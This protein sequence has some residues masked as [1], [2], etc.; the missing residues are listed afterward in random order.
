MLWNFLA[1]ALGGA[2]GSCI[3][4]GVSLCYNGTHSVFALPTL[5]VNVIGSLAIGLLY[6]YCSNYS[7]PTPMKMFLF[8]GLLGGFTTFSSFSL[9]TVNML[10]N[11][12]IGAA[13]VY[14]LGSLVVGVLM[15][16]GGVY[17]GDKL[18]GWIE[19]F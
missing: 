3:R 16:F 11:G 15:A 18:I 2:I 14:S 6:A 4:Y 12:Y 7:V 17:L 5:S 13:A 8:V 10:R 19:G 9:E 1:V